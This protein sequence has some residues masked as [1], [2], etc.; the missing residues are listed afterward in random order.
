MVA[1]LV[2][3]VIVNY[4]SGEMLGKCVE[5]LLKSTVPI[6]II[7]SDNASSDNSL[8]L[9]EQSELNKQTITIHRNNSNYGFSYANNAVFTK[10]STPF[11]LYL[12][13][14]CFVE[15]DTIENLLHTMH[16]HNDAGMVGCL[17]NNMDGSVQ[18]GCCGLTPTP[19]R[20][21]NQLLKL[22]KIFPNNPKFGGYL[23]S[24]EKLP[25]KPTEVEL[26]SGSCMFV[27]K[28]AIDEVGLLDDNYFLYCEDYDWFY[29][30]TQSD[31][32]IIFNP[33]TKVTH[34]K[35]FSTKQ[36]PFKVLLYKAKG[37]WRFYN[38]FFKENSSPATTLIIRVGIIARLFSLSG[39]L[40]F[41]KLLRTAS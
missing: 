39:L 38:K 9:L 7:I 3:V 22:S 37:M 21:L 13:P 27:R 41:K 30:F 5:H 32:K 19:A 6:Q 25:T 34:I 29:R 12:N 28:K 20:V 11:I 4:N 17:V 14:D 23:F 18:I 8:A 2:T 1:N 26:I 35:S 31:W 36:I 24:K 10:I 40:L 15:N 16:Q 33:N